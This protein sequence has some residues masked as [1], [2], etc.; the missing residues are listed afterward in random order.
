MAFKPKKK[1][2]ILAVLDQDLIPPKDIEKLPDE[3]RKKYDNEYDV[4]STLQELGHEVRIV[5]VAKDVRVIRASMEEFQSQVAFNMMVE[6]H[7][8]SMFE[9]HVVSYLELIG[10]APLLTLEAAFLS[11][12]AALRGPA[13]PINRLAIRR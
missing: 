5:G 8:Y 9:P 1:L 7:G 3:Q 12:Q 6:M 2:R 13:V 11:A 10:A 4:I